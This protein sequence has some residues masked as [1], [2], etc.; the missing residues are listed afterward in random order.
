MNNNSSSSSKELMN[1]VQHSNE[2][3]SN[4][5]AFNS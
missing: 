5:E 2:Y 3:L 4:K 1:M